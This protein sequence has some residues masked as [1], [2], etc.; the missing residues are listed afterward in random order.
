MVTL[1][2]KALERILKSG[3]RLV[4]D[5]I[6]LALLSDTYKPSKI[7]E[8]FN[9]IRTFEIRAGGYEAGGKSVKNKVLSSGVSGAETFVKYSFDPVEWLIE[10]SDVK[11][12]YF[13][14]YK[15][16]SGGVNV[17]HPLIA[18]GDLGQDEVVSRGKFRLSLP[19]TGLFRFSVK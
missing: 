13:I 14:L 4:E 6:R 1:Y 10:D 11:V 7:S 15:Y 5:D 12:R 3:I 17:N 18:Y 16:V 8:Y 2:D 19:S 9:S